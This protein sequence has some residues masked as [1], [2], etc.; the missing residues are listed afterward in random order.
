MLPSQSE[1]RVHGASRILGDIAVIDLIE[2]RIIIKRSAIYLEEGV[3][4]STYHAVGGGRKTYSIQFHVDF[5]VRLL[6]RV[7]THY[8]LSL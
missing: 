5:P 7:S 1:P 8:Y 3:V 4:I 2:L 6:H